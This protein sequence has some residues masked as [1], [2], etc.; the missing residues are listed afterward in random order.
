MALVVFK[1][2]VLIR[3]QLVSDEATD[4]PKM[5]TRLVHKVMIVIICSIVAC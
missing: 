5:G 2:G 1:L 4:T 3:V